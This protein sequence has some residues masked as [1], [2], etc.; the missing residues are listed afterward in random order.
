MA[1]KAR[2]RRSSGSRAARGQR[3]Q[4]ASS[5]TPKDRI[6]DAT[7]A[8]LATRDFAKVG[9]AD[10]AEEAGVSLATLRELYDG[11]LAIVADFSRRVDQA[12]LEGG[13]AEGGTPRDRLFEILMRRF[14]ALGPYKAAVKNVAR[15]A[16]RDLCLG[17]FLHKNSRRSQ[18][19]MLVAAGA[20]VS[21]PLRAVAV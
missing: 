20:D 10:V 18:S 9:L 12:V 11:K 14:D 1:R 17:R 16:R 13:A 19:W 21:G 4:R 8:L 6:I 15:A 2:P 5:G 3:A 7:M